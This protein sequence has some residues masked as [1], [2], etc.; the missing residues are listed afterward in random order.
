[1]CPSDVVS[2]LTSKFSVPFTDNA[3]SMLSF[4]AQ[5]RVFTT[6][7]QAAWSYWL[8]RESSLVSIRDEMDRC[9]K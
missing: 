9:T 1:M 5:A 6:A 4:Y 3:V 8:W 7:G 2:S